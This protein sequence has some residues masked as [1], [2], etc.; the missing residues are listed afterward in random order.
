M[1][2]ETWSRFGSRYHRGMESPF[3]SA[4][5]LL[6][7]VIDP[8]GNIPLFLSMLRGVTPKRRSWIILRESGVALAVLLAFLFFGTA[9]LDTLHLSKTSLGI[10][11]GIVLFLIAIRMIFLR[12]EEI[13]SDHPE[14]EPFIVPLAIPLIAGPAAVTSVLVLGQPHIGMGTTTSALVILLAM[15]IST[16]ALLGGEWI[17][18]LL[19]ERGLLA[20][21]RLLGMILTAIAVEMFLAGLREFIKTL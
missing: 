12:P 20:M 19:G 11:G 18:R 7:I 6:L 13:F 14:G 4:V 9:I 5:I 8:L 15:I 17:C 21:E 16:L 3:F 10:A 1:C 2:F